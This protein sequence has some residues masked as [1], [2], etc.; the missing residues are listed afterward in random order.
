MNGDDP[1]PVRVLECLADR[2]LPVA[3]SWVETGTIAAR[4]DVPEANVNSCCKLLVAR[5]LIEFSP[6][7]EENDGYAAIITIKGLR[8][9]GRGA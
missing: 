9:I 2:Y 5:G 6:P 1:L 7:D 3:S 8:S 4:L